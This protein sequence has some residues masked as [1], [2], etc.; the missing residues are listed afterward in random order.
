MNFKIGDTIVHWTHGLGTV[1]AI[2][3]MDLAGVTQQYYVVQVQLLKMWVPVDEADQGSIR[4][5]TESAKFEELFHILRRP[6]EPLSNQ[7]YQ[8]K[9]ALR[10]RMQKRTLEDLCHVIRDLTDHARQHT[11][12]Q[13]DAGVLFRA[14][15]HLL[16]EW[17]LALGAERSEALQELEDLL[18]EDSP[19]PKSSPIALSQ[20]A[21]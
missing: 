8:R 13:N 12:N 20:S 18:K 5:P 9:L 3:E 4:L 15:E 21:V 7:Q 10:E 16:D 11:L 14:E 6:G 1:I 19:Q 17:V 2:D